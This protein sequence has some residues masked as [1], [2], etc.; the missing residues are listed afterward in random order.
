M[1]VLIREPRRPDETEEDFKARDD[2]YFEA[3]EQAADK[4]RAL[5]EVH[6]SPKPR[7]KQ[8]SI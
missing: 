4:L 3:L 1:A 7:P 6:S 2:A 8:R 5:R